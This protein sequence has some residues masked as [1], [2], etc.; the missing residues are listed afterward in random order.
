MT[1]NR[2]KRVTGAKH[3][4]S[5]LQM[6]KSERKSRLFH[7]QNARQTTE[8]MPLFLSILKVFTPFSY[9]AYQRTKATSVGVSMKGFNFMCNPFGTT[10]WK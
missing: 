4:L 8:Q 2:A 3:L 10:D 6:S 9:Y 7:P 1:Q 5:L